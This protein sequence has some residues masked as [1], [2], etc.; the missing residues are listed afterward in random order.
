MVSDEVR[1]RDKMPLWLWWPV[2]AMTDRNH[3][4][5]PG[6]DRLSRWQWFS[7]ETIPSCEWA[8]ARCLRTVPQIQG[9]GSRGV[10]WVKWLPEIHLGGP[11]WYFDPPPQIFWK[12]IFSDTHPH[13]VIEAT[14]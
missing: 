14:S 1:D 8:H 2:Q 12:E 11:T 7:V 4:R 6:I 9:R 3:I 5:Q 13:V 10:K